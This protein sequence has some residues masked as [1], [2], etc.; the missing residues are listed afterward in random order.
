[1]SCSLS[2]EVPPHM[3]YREEMGVKYVPITRVIHIPKRCEMTEEERENDRKLHQADLAG[4]L[5]IETAK[6]L[7]GEDQ[8]KTAGGKIRSPVGEFIEKCEALLI[9]KSLYPPEHENHWVAQLPDVLLMCPNGVK[10]MGTLE[11]ACGSGFT[12]TSSDIHV[13]FKDT[14]V[15]LC[16]Y[17][18]NETAFCFLDPSTDDPDEELKIPSLQF[19]LRDP[20]MVGS[21]ETKDIMFALVCFYDDPVKVLDNFVKIVD[22]AQWDSHRMLPEFQVLNNCTFKGVLSG[23]LEG[24]ALTYCALVMFTQLPVTV[25]PLTDIEIVDLS[26]NVG[27]DMIVVFKDFERKVLQINSIDMR[28][29][30]FIK[31]SLDM[32]NVKYYCRDYLN[33]PKVDWN[34]K[35]KEILKDPKKFVESGG[36]ESLNLEDPKTLS[37]YNI[38]EDEEDEPC[39]WAGVFQ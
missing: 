14:S 31:G 7:L 8:S 4:S 30:N 28:K 15:A 27:V 25:V 37:Y 11:A 6:R 12:F 3:R 34:S 33:G 26:V 5:K 38:E 18:K 21:V 35:L 39:A 24:F 2:E 32:G 22:R 19:H 16:F 1:M 20:V 29:L 13:H 23:S 9:Q 17:L 36:W 10:I